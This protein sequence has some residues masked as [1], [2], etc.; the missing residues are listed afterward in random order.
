M[1]K[2]HSTL[3]R[4]D[5][6]SFFGCVVLLDDIFNPIMED[7]ESIGTND[8]RVFLIILFLSNICH[9]LIKRNQYMYYVNTCMYRFTYVYMCV[10]ACSKC[11]HAYNPEESLRILDLMIN[12]LYSPVLT[13]FA[14]HQVDVYINYDGSYKL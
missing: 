14:E 2:S 4:G 3:F 10:C 11:L 9:L 13:N 6:Y 8:F 7:P 12:E 5:F 1:H